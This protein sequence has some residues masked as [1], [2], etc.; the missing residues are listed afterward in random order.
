MNKINRSAI[1]PYSPQQMFRLVTDISSYP[2]F[3]PWCSEA[4]IIDSDENQT[5]AK[6][7][8]KFKGVKQNFTTRNINRPPDR[9]TIQLV[10]GPF[11]HMGGEW[12][13]RELSQS[14]CKIELD[15][16]FAF[17]SKWLEKIV[18][19]VFGVIGNTMVDSFRQR[20]KSLYSAHG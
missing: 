2:E 7:F 10:D 17:S 12:R 3:L 15:L 13:F 11:S 14:A 20:A 16:E 6:L 8:I 18:G 9:I 4:Q 5:T 19:P 1:V